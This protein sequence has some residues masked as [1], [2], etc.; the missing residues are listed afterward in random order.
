[1]G[2]SWRLAQAACIVSA[3]SIGGGETATA[4]RG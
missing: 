4:A 3:S 2:V 1:M